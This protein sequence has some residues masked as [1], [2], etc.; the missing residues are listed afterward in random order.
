MYIKLNP[1]LHFGV[2][3]IVGSFMDEDDFDIENWIIYRDKL[4]RQFSIQC[5]DQCELLTLAIQDLNV[6]KNNFRE[7]YIN[8]FENSFT[9]LRR[10]I[11]I[12]LK[13]ISYSNKYL[14]PLLNNEHDFEQSI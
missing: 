8:L 14:I 2:S 11:R 6:M 12:K 1:G 4:K 3:C 5:K 13:A 7:A 10:I 9:N